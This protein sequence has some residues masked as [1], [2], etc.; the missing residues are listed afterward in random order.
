MTERKRRRKADLRQQHCALML[1]MDFLTV[2]WRN[3]GRIQIES[4]HKTV[5]RVRI[6][7]IEIPSFPE[8]LYKCNFLAFMFTCRYVRY[9]PGRYVSSH[10]HTTMDNQRMSW[11]VLSWVW[12][13]AQHQSDPFVLRGCV[14]LHLCVFVCV[15]LGSLSCPCWVPWP[16][17][18]SYI[19]GAWKQALGHLERPISSQRVR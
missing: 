19:Q 5:K 8:R 17:P 10:N 1:F 3:L 7:H 16:R 9:I 11:N 2:E 6:G 4:R 12:S 14:F 13:K 15:Y 18:S